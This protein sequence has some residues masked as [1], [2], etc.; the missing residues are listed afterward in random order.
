MCNLGVNDRYD[1]SIRK[2]ME[3]ANAPKEEWSD[4]DS[5]G[6]EV[7]K[8]LYADM[9]HEDFRHL[10]RVLA[11]QNGAKFNVHVNTD[12]NRELYS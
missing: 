2:V 8:Q 12:V 7:V 5:V 10:E 6:G 11:Q 3:Q 1:H 9:F 4:E